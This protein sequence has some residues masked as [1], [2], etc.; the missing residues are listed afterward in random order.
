MQRKFL[1]GLALMMVLNVLIKPIAIFGIDAKVQNVVGTEQYGIYFPLL[2]L[3]FLL[4]ILTDFG[5]NNYTIKH[6]AQQPNVALSYLGKILTLRIFL[7]FVYAIVLYTVAFLFDWNQ[8]QVYLLSFLVL[9]QLFV[10]TIAFARSYFN[11]MLMFKTEAF[12]SVL[13]RL[14]LII[15]CGAVLYVPALLPNHGKSF[16]I[17]W[18][19]WIQTLCYGITFLIALILLLRK[20]GL[21]KLAFRRH[22]S[23][24]IIRKSIPYALVILLM[25][26]YTRI[27]SVMVSELHPKGSLEAGYYAQGFRLFDALFMFVMIFTGLLYPIFSQLL[28]QQKD[29]KSILSSATKLLLGATVTVG[30]V[31]FF[32]AELILGWIYEHDVDKSAPAFQWLMLGFVGMSANLLFGTLLT[33]N[34][35]LKFLNTISAVGILINVIANTLLIPSYGA[36]GAALA[37]LITQGAVSLVQIVYC[38]RHFSLRLSMR[39]AGKFA[40]FVGSVWA[41]CFFV[42]VDSFGM[43]AAV[44]CASILAM[45]LFGLIDFKQLISAFT[46]GPKEEIAEG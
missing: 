36:S 10:A 26:L 34:G 40:G 30:V 5:I 45:F 20:T 39:E 32:N 33:A 21:P 7:F 3:T 9:N 17:E 35:S 29:F 31:S 28:I 8:F 13:D 46:S 4:N 2:S 42:Q 41:L 23:M 1:S 18:F 16:R 37:T 24:V 43:F 38:M 25:Q 12:L 14:L 11:G 15:F 27:D 22:F 6:V 44:G 19:V